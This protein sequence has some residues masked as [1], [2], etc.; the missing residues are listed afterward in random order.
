MQKQPIEAVNEFYTTSLDVMKRLDKSGAQV[1]RELAG[2][3]LNMM[4]LWMDCWN[5]QLKVLLSQDTPANLF[6]AQSGIATEF[7]MRL[8]DQYRKIF[9]LTMDMGFE[10]M[11]CSRKLKP[12]WVLTPSAESVAEPSPGEAA[13]EAEKAAPRMISKSKK[14][15]V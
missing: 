8:I 13:S 4:R 12:F 9:T 14:T 5:R 6:A 3:Q 11:A 10:L 2:E 7:S 1:W 15:A